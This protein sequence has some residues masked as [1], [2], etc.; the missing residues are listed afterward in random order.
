MT[1]GN[2]SWRVR[3][4]TSDLSLKR[5]YPGKSNLLKK[6]SAFA[7]TYGGYVIIGI[8][9]D[10]KGKVKELCG[11]EKINRF[12][13]SII[14][15]C[16]EEIYPPIV[17]TVSPP[18]PHPDKPD[19]FFYVIYV[20][21]SAETPHILN[22]SRNGLYVRTD[23]YSQKFL[24]RLAK[25]DE[26]EFLMNKRKKSEDFL[27]TLL[28][29][30][31][32]RLSTHKLIKYEEHHGTDSLLT[33]CLVPLLPQNRMFELEHLVKYAQDSTIKARGGTLPDFSD[34]KIHSQFESLISENPGISYY[35]YF[36][37]NI[38]NMLYYV[39]DVTR[40]YRGEERVGPPLS[41][42]IP[43]KVLM[44]EILLFLRYAQNFYNRSGFDGMLKF[45]ARMENIKGRKLTLEGTNSKDI[46]ISFLDNALEMNHTY[47]VLNL[48]GEKE[49]AI[50]IFKELCFSLGFK[51]IY[52]LCT[53][54]MEELYLNG[55]KYLNWD[56]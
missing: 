40:E 16:F 47:S 28:E 30:A 37:I 18:I 42:V 15:W 35:S 38:Y 46:W 1:S 3:K 7:N 44:A 54:D 22:K 33:L 14:Q 34:N 43:L 24:T 4:K 52:S 5:E 6:L 41:K 10:G 12:D 49:I 2:F 23:E 36:E 21:Q 25:F 20:E 17:P 53:E 8:D 31:N 27:N 51:K 50:S 39:C 55:M 56:Y 48:V 11:T 32:R 29:R 45:I 19:R 13:Q 9:E 26:L